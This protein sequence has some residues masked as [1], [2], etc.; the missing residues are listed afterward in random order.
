MGASAPS[1]SGVDIMKVWV[2]Q[3][4]MDYEGI[5]ILGLYS[6]MELAIKEALEEPAHFPGGWV[7][8]SSNTWRN[9]CDTVSVWEMEVRG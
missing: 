2:G 6:N 5:R 1:L 8:E 4:G 7:R 9:G 3:R